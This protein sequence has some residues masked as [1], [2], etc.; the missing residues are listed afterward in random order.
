MQIFIIGTPLETALSLD[1]KRFHRQISEAK[2]ILKA[3]NGLNK[4]R[5]PLIEMY[6]SNIEWLTNYILIFEAVRVNDM[7]FAEYLNN[8]TIN[9]T[10]NFITKEYVINMKKR[11]YTKDKVFYK[12]WKSLG[13]SNINMYWVNNEWK[14][15]KQ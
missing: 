3:I 4:W 7:V 13:E 14:I 9:I 11:L 2:I 15:I 5:G 12:K 6:K 10:P 8:L 1:S